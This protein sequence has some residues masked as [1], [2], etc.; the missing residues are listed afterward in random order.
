MSDK[1]GDIAD[2]FEDIGMSVNSDK[3]LNWSLMVRKKLVEDYLINPANQEMTAPHD[4]KEASVVTKLLSD[5]DKISLS[6]L[7][8]K[9][10]DKGLELYHEIALALADNKSLIVSSTEE[11]GEI[12]D[13]APNAELDDSLIPEFTYFEGECEISP[14]AMEWRSFSKEYEENKKGV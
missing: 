5:M 14:P 8:L 11:F 10:E 1:H 7:R 6:R 4:V 2:L 9:Q 12:K 13:I 3:Q